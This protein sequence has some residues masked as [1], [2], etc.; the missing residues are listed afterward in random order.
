MLIFGR[1]AGFVSLAPFAAQ[2]INAI[3]TS[4]F[5]RKIVRRT[6]IKDIKPAA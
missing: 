5:T 4:L 6:K 3:S 1:C 2:A